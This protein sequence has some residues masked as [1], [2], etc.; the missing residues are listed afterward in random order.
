MTFF[1][2]ANGACSA[3]CGTIFRI[4]AGGTLTTVHSFNIADGS[5][6]DAPLIQATD[7]NLYGTT[8]SGGAY[9]GG[10]V[11]R[12][13]PPVSTTTV[14]TSAPNPSN[15]GQPVTMTATVTAENNLIPTGSVVFNSNGVQVGSA[16]L[17]NSGV[18]V[19][20]YAGLPLGIDS[21]Q[22][23]YQ[24]STPFT[25]ST[26]N[27]VLQMVGITTTSVTSA[28]DPSTVGQT[29]TV[30]ATVTPGAPGGPTPTGT[31][32]FTSNSVA[33]PS[34]T[35]VTLNQSLTAQCVTSTLAVG[36][37]MIVAT[38]SGDSNYVGGSGSLV[39]IVNPVPTP[40]QFVPLPPCRV[41]DTRNPNGPFGGPAI[42]GHSSRDFPL[43]QNGNPCNIP[44]SAVA[45]SL[46]VTVVPQ[47]TLGYLTIWPTG[48]GQPTVSTLNSLD[49]RV[50]ADAAIVPAGTPSGSV[51]GVCNRYH[52][53]SAGHRRLLHR[54]W[55]LHTAVLSIDSLSPGGHAPS[56]RD[57][58]RAGDGSRGAAPVPACSRARRHA[59]YPAMRE[60]TR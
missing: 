23:V 45:Y 49:G 12:L 25:G 28:P 13:I 60:P 58:R 9:G 27:M 35:D 11:F 1:G 18:A 19:L 38:Y 22:A 56:Q 40:V 44:S 5:P 57:L 31:V 16:S 53:R 52:E 54:C 33:I 34:C 6:P 8:P 14:L 2:G 36:T 43:A 32:S 10:T 4:T 29:V 30:T 15:L 42:G 55:Q 47:H 26:S 51:S 24:G 50:K 41:V 20:I 21:L 17:N 46:N 59:L 39:Q 7:G 48:E 37:D 3:G